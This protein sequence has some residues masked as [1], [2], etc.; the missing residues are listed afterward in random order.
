MGGYSRA[1]LDLKAGTDGHVDSYYA[2]LYS[3]W[4]NESGYYIDALIKANR[5]QNRSDVLMSDGRRAGGDY[6]NYGVG[7]SVE[8]GKHIKLP[9]NWFV[10]PFAQVSALWVQ[11][12]KYGLDNG[13]Q[14]RS[15]HAN[16]LIGKIGTHLGRRIEL[17]D[18]GILQ[19]YLKVAAAQEFAKANKVRI[20]D[21]YSFNN[22]LSGGRVEVGA[23]VIAQLSE[24]IQLHGDVDYGNGR[25]ME[26]PWGVSLGVRYAW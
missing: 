6:D 4:L 17:P 8:V 18:G 24:A 9:S 20:N 22:D 11:G 13:M 25:N 7:G 5:F 21:T 2:G 12:E 26:Q 10:E 3:T 1:N 16:S 14:A 15:N 19:P 23:G